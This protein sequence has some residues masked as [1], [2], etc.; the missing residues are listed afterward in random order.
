MALFNVRLSAEDAQRVA[1]L[2]GAGVAVSDVVREAIRLEHER[3]LGRAARGKRASQVVAAVIADL[4]DADTAP[5]QP[6][7]ARDRAAVRKHVVAK[8][9]R[10]P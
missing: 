2:R 7:D 8:L 10:R 4:P 5:L 6:V 9:R 1:D 3:R